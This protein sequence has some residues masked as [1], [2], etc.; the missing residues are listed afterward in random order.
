ML[1]FITFLVVLFSG[2]NAVA[3][4]YTIQRAEFGRSERHQYFLELLNL[5]VKNSGSKTKV[6]FVEAKNDRLQGYNV[7]AVQKGKLDVI[8]TM[9]DSKRETQL[10]PIRIPLYKGML[11]HR[12]CIIQKD[13]LN[14]FKDI[15][16]IED[17]ERRRLTI[18][19]GHDWPDTK[20]LKSNGL[21]V[22]T[23][24]SYEGLFGMLKKGR[25]D[26]YAR[27]INEPWSEID[28]F[29][30]GSLDIDRHISLIYHSPVYF[31]VGKQHNQLAKMIESGLNK[32][33]DSGEFDQLFEKYNG[34][35]LKLAELDKR[36][37]IRLKNPDLSSGSK[38]IVDVAKYWLKLK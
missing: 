11:G 2:G 8:W 13:K 17:F 12:I 23:G 30:S 38:K 10:L 14:R 26:C 18:G 15:R 37:N 36:Q 7:R 31:F 4:T 16:S 29:G 1:G 32:S 6:T 25:F 9:T 34:K 19:Q 27:G 5:A 21:Q 24:H 20:V 35:F 33:I 3:E 28:K 22:V